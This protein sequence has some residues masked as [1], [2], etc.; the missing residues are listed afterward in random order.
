MP[1]SN[2]SLKPS[3]CHAL[4]DKPIVRENYQRLNAVP[5]GDDTGWIDP[6]LDEENRLPGQ[7]TAEEAHAQEE[8][9]IRQHLNLHEQRLAAVLAVLKNSDAHRVLD[10]GCGEGCLLQLLL[11]E[12]S[13]TQIVGV[14]ISHRALEVAKKR[15]HLEQLTPMQRQRIQL[16]QGELTCHDQRFT[17]YEAAA[18]VEVIEHLDS[19]SLAAFEQVLFEYLRPG[20]IVCTT[21]NAEYNVKLTNLPSGKFRH[22]DHRFEWTRAE[23]QAWANGVAERFD[24]Y[25]RFLPVGPEDQTLGAPTQMG[26]FTRLPGWASLN[27][28]STS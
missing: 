14:D 8:L 26:I 20:L 4:Q 28:P 17:E 22:K 21:P 16:I 9:E 25:V 12:K 2:L 5:Q 24:Y 3:L 27:S 19:S 11:A 10:L 1:E 23:F 13:F 15:L 6:W 18:I 7:D